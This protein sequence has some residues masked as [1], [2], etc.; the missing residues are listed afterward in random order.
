MPRRPFRTSSRAAVVTALLASLAVLAVGVT[1]WQPWTTDGP[2]VS[3]AVQTPWGPLSP[4]DRD[5]LVKVRLTCLWEA[6]TGQHAQQHATSPE[7]K[8]VTSKILAEH[9]DL[10]KK[11]RDVAGKLGVPLPDTP[12]AQQVAWTQEI[13]TATGADYDRTVVQRLRE[14]DGNVLPDA[15]QARVSTGNDLIRVFARDT[16]DHVTRNVGYLEGT[17]L[18][19]YSALPEPPAPDLPAVPPNWRELIVPGLVLLACLVAAVWLGSILLGRNRSGRPEANSGGVVGEVA[20]R[21]VEPA[22]HP[23]AQ[24]GAAAVQDGVEHVGEDPRL[25]RPQPAPEQ[26]LDELVRRGSPER[27]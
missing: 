20:G 4:A 14:A 24:K 10:D 1:M 15:Q 17:G 22:L 3:D 7:V 23:L 6:S 11:V 8:E 26:P 13:T 25:L 5:L 16:L 19:D 18:V 9:T 12:D 21:P 2:G 27:G